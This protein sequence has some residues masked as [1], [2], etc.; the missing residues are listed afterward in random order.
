ME[1]LRKPKR[2]MERGQLNERER[3]G[4]MSKG[5]EEG[6]QTERERERDRR[7]RERERER[8]RERDR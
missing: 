8:E 5:W 7:K 3:K 1:R 6:K 4:K 2:R